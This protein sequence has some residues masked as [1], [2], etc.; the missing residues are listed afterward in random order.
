MAKSSDR[1]SASTA[2]KAK[3]SAAASGPKTKSAA[4]PSAKKSKAKS[5][6]K[7]G[8]IILI[9]APMAEEP[10]P[11]QPVVDA[12]RQ[13]A[14]KTKTKPA[15]G[16]QKPSAV[17]PKKKPQKQPAVEAPMQ[18]VAE[19]E[20]EPA[21]QT[22]TDSH[23]E[24]KDEQGDTDRR[25]GIAER[26]I[27]EEPEEESTE[28]RRPEPQPKASSN[29]RELE[30][31]IRIKDLTKS[32]GPQTIFE[33]VTFD[34]P[35]GEISIIL[36]PSGTGKSVFLKHLVGLLRP[37]RGEVWIGDYNVPALGEKELY[38]VRK[39]FGVLFQDGA[40]FGR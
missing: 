37:D 15:T 34:V 13:P 40:L 12:G 17:K 24:K 10:Q 39:K 2:P 22:E 3:K 21:A 16:A 6:S 20:T 8:P 5:S 9:P 23:P 4:K 28:A 30:A 11:A 33:D 29:G 25:L 32:F 1:K 27:A 19:P 18:P 31:A 35:K 38:Q 26:R 14:A 7:K 36:G